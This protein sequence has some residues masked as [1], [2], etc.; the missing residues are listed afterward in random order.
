MEFRGRRRKE[1]RERKCWELRVN[2]DEGIFG[3]SKAIVSNN[4][5]GGPVCHVLGTLFIFPSILT[6]IWTEGVMACN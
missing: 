1:E 2:S 5:P 3:F 4:C 6:V